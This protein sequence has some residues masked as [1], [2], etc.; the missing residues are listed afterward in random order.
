[1]LGY[2]K[3]ADMIWV[4]L[5]LKKRFKMVDLGNLTWVVRMCVRY[6]LERG[7]ISVDQS[8][9]LQKVLAHFGMHESNA[10][11]T[12]LP[13]KLALTAATDAEVEAVRD[14]PYLEAFGSLMYAM[15]G[16]HP[17]IAYAVS[18]LSRFASCPG[19][20]HV[21]AMKHLFQ[22]LKGTTHLGI[23]FSRD[24]GDLTGYSDSDYAADL[25]TRKSISG[26]IFTLTG[27][28]VS[29]SSKQQTIVGLST[30]EVE[31]VAAAEACKEIIWLHRL[32][33]ELGNGPTDPTN[34]FIDNRGT[35]LL[36]K[37]PVNHSHT[38][39]IDVWYHFIQQCIAM[40]SVNVRQIPT[41]ENPADICTKSLGKQKIW[42][43]RNLIGLSHVQP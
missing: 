29:W 40:K 21:T 34:L 7:Q 10:V 33:H 20:Q 12:P 4:C 3:D 28:P 42:H 41:A 1:M 27:G 17:D 25:S 15:T 36:A 2:Q 19:S 9:Y 14:F 22:Y 39:H 5:K 16:T 37:N 31:Y 32:L 26:T 8:L 24:G 38:E 23:T 35:L 18:T 11:S 43:F 6:N 30:T 13:E